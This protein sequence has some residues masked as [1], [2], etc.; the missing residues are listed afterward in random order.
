MPRRGLSEV[1]GTEMVD[2]IRSKVLRDRVMDADGAVERFIPE[3]GTIAFSCM[4]GS[5][6]AKEIPDALARSADAGRRYELNLLTGGSTTDR[7]E[8]C[9]ARL[10]VRRRFPYLSGA[11][12]KAVNEGSIEFFDVRIGEYPDLVRQGTLTAG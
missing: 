9:V 3:R 1:R 2:R 6:L 11:A 12:R 8:A 7:F 5:A 10:G 4:G